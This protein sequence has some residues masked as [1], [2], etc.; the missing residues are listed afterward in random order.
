MK[1]SERRKTAEVEAE[2]SKPEAEQP[3]WFLGREIKSASAEDK[4]TEPAGE[5]KATAAEKPEAPG[6]EP[7]RGPSQLEAYMRYAKMR[8]PRN[9]DDEMLAPVRARRFS[10]GDTI[11]GNENEPGWADDAPPRRRLRRRTQYG[12]RLRDAV[13]AGV[14]SV[15]VGALGGA[16]VYDRANDGALSTAAFDSLGNFL[17]GLNTPDA[18]T[19]DTRPMGSNT[20]DEQEAAAAIKK[21]ISTARLDVTDATGTLNT[22]I[23]LK[24][25]A[26]P[27]LP[28]QDIN[29]RLTGLPADA[30]L[31]A[32]TKGADNAWILKPGEE[33][34]LKLMVPSPPPSPLLIA[35]DAIE[36]RTGDLAAPTE[37]IKVALGNTG[38]DTTVAPP[39]VEPASAPPTDV[40]RNFNLPPVTQHET[41]AAQ[42]IPAPLEKDSETATSDSDSLMRNGTKL[43]DLGDISAARAFFSKAR[44]L[45]NREA[46]LRLGQTYDPVVFRDKN[47]QGLKPDPTMAL[48]Y[49]LE[50]RTAGIEDA[51]SAITG[52]ETWLKQ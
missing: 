6:D 10:P 17:T 45:G 18:R 5:N 4:P 30:Y 36:P 42:P 1:S 51:N 15:A 8:E 49:Y 2:G 48:K 21:P 33:M 26:E 3:V 19:A 38:T 23:P 52:L 35:V 31:T 12:L 44:D 28:N 27:A 7:K 13:L 11:A 34:D 41:A 37:E 14:A 40:K 50:A 43:L 47:V 22:L 32:G 46:S 20:Q 39:Q 16:V 24:I 9:D 29:L 25:S